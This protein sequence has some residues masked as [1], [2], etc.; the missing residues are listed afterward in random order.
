[1]LYDRNDVCYARY[2]LYNRMKI[3][4]MNELPMKQGCLGLDRLSVFETHCK[5]FCLLDHHWNRLEF[6]WV[7]SEPLEQRLICCNN[8]GFVED[9]LK[10]EFTKVLFHR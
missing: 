7:T 10:I 3:G 6:C 4:L 1:M 5:S 2:I 8:A 9:A